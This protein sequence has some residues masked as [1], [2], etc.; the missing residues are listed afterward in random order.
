MNILVVHI[1][2]FHKAKEC[3]CHVP[4]E[5]VKLTLPKKVVNQLGPDIS[6]IFTS[7]KDKRFDENNSKIKHRKKFF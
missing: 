5:W 3:I 1:K 2:N 6:G 7:L 4:L